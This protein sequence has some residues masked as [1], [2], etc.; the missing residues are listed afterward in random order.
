M[1][2]PLILLVDDA[3]EMGLI[4]RRL[5]TRSGCVV[6]HCSDATSAWDFLRDHVPDLVLLDVNLIGMS[7]PE[8]C[9]KLR[10]DSKHSRL[11]VA[12]FTHEGLGDD[13]ALGLEAGVDFLF[14][15]DLVAVPE[16]WNARLTEILDALRS[17]Q[18]T[19]SLRFQRS[20]VELPVP[21]D[22]IS[23]INSA[24]RPP[25]LRGQAPRVVR[26]ILR[27]ALSQVFAPTDTDVWLTADG[28]ALEETRVP[29][30]AATDAT[31]LVIALAQQIWCVT[32][33][34]ASAPVRAALTSAFPAL[35]EPQM[36]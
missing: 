24:L 22:W 11:P 18:A 2:K 33:T 32:G 5:G 34:T 12:L 26:A 30:E 19:G 27:R 7:G 36:R 1:T 14:L 31:A 25:T 6:E 35:P 16:S 29:P 17:R 13:V 8:L 23:I 28:C 15:K 10:A 20:E 9:R 4:V 21:A 3:R